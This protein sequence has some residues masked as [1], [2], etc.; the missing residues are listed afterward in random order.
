MLWELVAR[1]GLVRPLFL[2]P[3]STVL[4]Q[5]PG[6]L[7][8]GELAGPL[9][10]SLYRAAVGLVIAMVAGLA[11]GLLIARMRWMR[12]L[13]G[14]L[15]AFGSPAP[16]IALLPVFILWF[17]IGHVSKIV[18]VAIT[19]IFP[20]ILA[21]R[22]AAEAVPVRQIWAA[23]A[24]GTS[25]FAL[26]RRI[27]LPASV[28]ALLTGV[29]IAIPYAMITAF[30]AEMIAGGGGLGGTLVMAQRYFETPTV[31]VDI[32]LMMA[33]GYAVDIAIVALRRRVVRWHEE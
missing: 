18:L 2:P 21:A 9:L 26:V 11:I 16:K 17:G 12:I 22:A 32:L 28:P 23:R 8:D 4:A 1:L 20:F 3:L 10:I 31:F 6:L 30:T 14:P 5:I 33:V 27:V 24:M 15:V 7:R 19:A 29:R 25:G 13:L